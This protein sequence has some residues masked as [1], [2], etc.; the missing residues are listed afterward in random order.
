MET[1]HDHDG[2]AL[3][4][5]ALLLMADTQRLHA[6]IDEDGFEALLTSL[7]YRLPADVRGQATLVIS[8]FLEVSEQTGPKLLQQLHYVSC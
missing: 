1:G 2:R 6:F 5:I 4:G 3:K 7:D 8:K